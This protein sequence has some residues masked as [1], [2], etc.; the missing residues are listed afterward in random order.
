MLDYITLRLNYFVDILNTL[1]DVY[2]RSAGCHSIQSENRMRPTSLFIIRTCLG[3]LFE[4][5]NIPD[6]YHKYRQTL[7][8]VHKKYDDNEMSL[9]QVLVPKSVSDHF[10]NKKFMISSHQMNS[11][12]NTM[13]CTLIT[14]DNAIATQSMD[15]TTACVVQTTELS[16]N[17]I[18][19]TFDP[20]MENI[21]NAACPFLRDFRVSIMPTK[22]SKTVSRSGKFRHITTKTTTES[23]VTKNTHDQTKLAEAFLQSQSLS[24][25]RTIEFVIERTVSAVIKDFQIEILIP[26]K[27]TVNEEI[28][29]IVEMDKRKVTN[30]M[31]ERFQNAQLRLN[32]KW[33]EFLPQMT[34][35][36]VKVN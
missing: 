27:R 19:S 32:R 10:V 5:S 24:V 26:M 16:E 17:H 20:M 35:E 25:R 14:I 4:Q 15:G 8:T 12:L 28:N 2:I 1:Y 34:R 7:S 6:E 36:R 29:S 9:V 30:E 13:Q 23:K 31:Y 22:H 33:D 3:W 21:L 18:L 11:C